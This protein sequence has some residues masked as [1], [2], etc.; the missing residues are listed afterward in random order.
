[1]SASSPPPL[2]LFYLSLVVLRLVSALLGYAYIH[3][4]EWFQSGEA[5]YPDLFATIQTTNTWEFD[6]AFPCRSMASIRLANFPSLIYAALSRPDSRPTPATLFTLQRLT[7]FATS[8][9]LDYAVFRLSARRHRL[10]A[11][12]LLAS[13]SAILTFQV[14]PFSNAI[15]SVA[16]ALSLL[17]YRACTHHLT[18]P[19]PSPS[20]LRHLVPAT[21]LGALASAGLFARFTFVLFFLPVGLAFLYR[22]ASGAGTTA[23]RRFGTLTAAAAGF[24]ATSAAHVVYD[25]HYYSSEEAGTG[26]GQEGGRRWVVTPLNAFLYNVKPANVA[27]HGVH[28]RWLHAVVNFPMVVGVAMAGTLVSAAWGEIKRRSR[29]KERKTTHTDEDVPIP[30]AILASIL[31]VSIGGLSISPH[32]EPRFLLPLV[33]PSTLLVARLLGGAGGFSARSKRVVLLLFLFQHVLQFLFFGFLHQAGIVS[34]LLHFPPS[35][36]SHPTPDPV[37]IYA[38]KTFMLPL[39]LVPSG[40][41]VRPLPSPAHSAT[42]EERYI[43]PAWALDS[44]EETQRGCKEWEKLH[45]AFPHVDTDRLAETWQAVRKYGWREGLQVVLL[46]PRVCSQ[47]EE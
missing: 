16:L 26:M 24:V 19:S 38:G 7:F 18:R 31:V 36:S 41:R 5:L 29:R 21:A 12:C 10:V 32:Q 25:S 23:A 46:Q 1:M 45:T 2:A 15:E 28:P 17:A 3:P 13:S 37:E 9:A 35:A 4:D 44:F 43:L 11:L 34:L 27:V 22:C 33:V 8:F 47:S 6:P 20:R 30:N 40:C 42:E 39:H 14:R